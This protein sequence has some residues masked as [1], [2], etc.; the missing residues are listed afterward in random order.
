MV[1]FFDPNWKDLSKDQLRILNEWVFQDGGGIV[2]IPGPIHT[3]EL[4]KSPPRGATPETGY[5]MLYIRNMLPVIP[6]NPFTHEVKG[7][8]LRRL[9]FPQA[10]AEQEF[11]RLDE[12][13]GKG[14]WRKGWDA[15][16]NEI[17]DE[18]GKRTMVD[19]LGSPERGFYYCFPS[20]SIK[21]NALVLAAFDDPS[22]T[23]PDKKTPLPFLASG[24]WGD[25][26]V[27][28]LA[29]GEM[30][31]LRGYRDSY[32]ERFWTKLLRD[33]G[34]KS[35][36]TLN[37]RITPVMSRYGVV[38][39]FQ[40][41]EAR[42]QDLLGKPLPRKLENPP[43]LL[44]TLPEGVQAQKGDLVNVKDGDL[45]GKP[46][47]VVEAF[48]ETGP[49]GSVFHKLK[50]VEVTAKKDTEGN[51]TYSP[52]SKAAVFT[53]DATKTEVF[54]APLNFKPRSSLQE[55]RERLA[56]TNWTGAMTAGSR[57]SSSRADGEY[58]MKVVYEDSADNF[59][60]HK[61]IVRKSNPETDNVR[62]DMEALWEL[63]GN[64]DLVFNRIS[65]SAIRDD[66]RARLKQ[67]ATDSKDSQ[68]K[69]GKS[70]RTDNG[71]RLL[72]DLDGA[73]VIPSCMKTDR[74]DLRNRGKV[75][76]Q[77]D[78]GFV[79][80]TDPNGEK[81]PVKLSYVLCLVVGLLSVEWLIRKLLRLA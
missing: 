31:R 1:V 13:T 63:A 25:G 10:T 58:K 78:D 37:K 81:D 45:A 59:Y 64:A 70:G 68:G 4:T 74:K 3:E 15:F 7:D 36:N 23:M 53:V 49:D 20:K 80:W 73:R 19:P 51:I 47:Q 72:L 34:S 6:D 28:W 43:R 27:V 32:H 14:D 50:V 40:T 38:N 76:D 42:F 11:M 30:W 69:A 48:K 35:V 26:K 60:P 21:Q 29:S 9:T 77:W 62:P 54:I 55:G 44:V 33:V 41:F 46:A 2:F 22:V 75:R 5:P 8:K 66:L 52:V 57:W 17:Q 65:D 18:D 67:G 24:P 16:F 61:F 56:R 71:P 39:K 79:V 12:D